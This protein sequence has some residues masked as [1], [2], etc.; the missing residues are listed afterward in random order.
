M[1]RHL[2]IVCLLLSSCRSDGASPSPA[3]EASTA[4]TETPRKDPV[5]FNPLTPAE[6][7]VILH[8]GTE[9]AG[10]GEYT[11]NQATGTYL[12]RQCNAP[13][14][15]SGD[16]FDS[17]CGWPSFDDEILGAVTR[18]VDA[19]GDRT[20]IVCANCGG[21]LGHV[22]LGEGFTRKNVRHCVNSISMRFVP[23]GGELPPVIRPAR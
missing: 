3:P 15:R 2:A 6:A 7:R 23:A 10:T 16:K 17:H 19:D 8:K 9:R 13:L 1:L 12:C 18:H 5:A 20:E 11:E 22:F 21:H 14:Y 4:M